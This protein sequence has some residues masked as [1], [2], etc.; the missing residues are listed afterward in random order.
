VFKFYLVK[1]DVIIKWN[2]HSKLG[3]AP[4]PSDGVSTYRQ[5]DQGHIKL[6]RL[7][8]TLSRGNTI[9]HDMKNSA[10]LVLDE[11]PSEKCS[12]N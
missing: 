7:G 1:V 5:Q 8:A 10:M 11:L 12:T 9:A 4:K 6:E 2:H 3:S